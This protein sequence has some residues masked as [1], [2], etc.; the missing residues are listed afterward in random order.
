MSWTIYATIGVFGLLLAT[1]VAPN[2]QTTVIYPIIG[3]ILGLVFATCVAPR[4]LTAIGFSTA[5]VVA[6]SMAA[7]F[8]SYIGNVVAGSLFSLFQSVGAVGGLSWITTSA[9]T[10]FGTFIG[11]ITGYNTT[12]S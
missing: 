5:G 9:V 8:Q 7:A 4:C 2:I 6:G 11:A 12:Q 10:A 1:I 3:G